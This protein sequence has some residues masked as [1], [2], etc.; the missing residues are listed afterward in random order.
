MSLSEIINILKSNNVTLQLQ[1]EQLKLIGETANLTKEFIAEIKKRKEGLISFLKETNNSLHF[2]PIQIAPDAVHYSLTGAQKQIWIACQFAGGNAAYTL[3]NSFYLKG[4]NAQ[5]LQQVFGIL[6]QRHESLRTI[7]KEVEGEPRQFILDEIDFTIEQA[8]FKNVKNK[9]KKIAEEEAWL[10]HNSFS[11]EHG[12]LFNVRL[13]ELSETEH[14]LLLSMHHI[15]SDG[16]SVGL[17]MQELISIYAATNKSVTAYPPLTIQYKDYANWLIEKQATYNYTKERNYW[18]ERLSYLPEPLT[19]PC[20]FVRPDVKKQEGAISR[21][22]LKTDQYQAIQ[23]LCKKLSINLF[24]FLHAAIGILLYKYTGQWRTIVG[25]PVSGRQHAENQ[26]GLYVNTLALL[27]E[28][29]PEKSIVDYLKETAEAATRDF[30]HQAYPFDQL[31]DALTIK[32]EAGRAPLFDVMLVLQNTAIA[33]KSIRIAKENNIEIGFLDKYL[34]KNKSLI[35]LNRAAKF[36]L[37]FDFLVEGQDTLRVEIEYSTELF[38]EERICNLGRMFTHILS[39]ILKHP[40]KKINQLEL[41]NASERRKLVHQFNAPITEI[42]HWQLADLLKPSFRKHREKTALIYGKNE[43]SYKTIDE[44]SDQLAYY[45]TSKLP[46]AGNSLVGIFM[47][48]TE[49]TLITILGVLK[50]GAT[51]VPIDPSYPAARVEFMLED[52]DPEFIITDK[53][54]KK[55]VPVNFRKRVI[56]IN[57]EKET[58]LNFPKQRIYPRDLREKTAYLIYTSG[59]TGKP[60]GVEICHRNVIAFLQWAREEFIN[61]P[62]DL[63]YATTS[64]CFDLSI[65]EFFFPLLTGKTIRLL[66]SAMEIVHYLP[67]DRQVMLNTVPSV[68]RNLLEEKIDLSPVSALNIAGEAVPKKFKQALP[69]SSI[70]VRNLYG[71][72]EDTTYSTCYLFKED[73]YDEVPIGKPISNTQLYILDE[74]LHVLPEGVDGEIYLSGQGIAKG[75]HELPE[76]TKEKFLS[77]PFVKGR[78]LYKT[79]DV[80]R[81]LPDGQVMFTGRIDDQVKVRGYRIELGEIQFQLEHI[82]GIEQAMNYLN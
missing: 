78:L 46:T 18:K 52:A 15:I 22:Y 54:V 53:K 55:N 60:K 10:Q 58:I 80:G 27:T 36:D 45:L 31:V 68:V 65:F 69:Y 6:I 7:F 8:D 20:D 67:G 2:E 42:N 41:L 4:V 37:T 14:A 29:D 24:N 11:L 30:Q 38:T 34:Y 3:V 57:A 13:V 48:R 77:N 61:T 40:K 19:I 63:L 76:L 49:W 43:F 73:G 79:G 28:T 12:P 66:N 62:F 5:R 32:R 75:Y 70:E 72:S 25:T 39:Q 16:W 82:E 1:G 23:L 26:L 21:F 35:K 50:A 51:Y 44:Y 71:P 81:W 74:Y 64:Y 47:E 9:A 33:E 59:S 56:D 17:L